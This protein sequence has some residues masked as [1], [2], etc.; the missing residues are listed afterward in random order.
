M[1]YV[2]IQPKTVASPTIE[3]SSDSLEYDGTA[4]EPDV[5]AVKDG[6]NVIPASEYTV[7]Y[8][9]NVNV[10]TAAKVII[11]DV[12]GG[13]Y[14]VSGSRNFTI[15]A[16]AASLINP[17]QPNNLTYT[18]KPQAL[19]TA[20]TAANGRVMYSLE[21]DGTYST[22]IPRG[23]DAD[24]YEVWYKVV[25][26]DGTTETDPYDEPVYVTIDL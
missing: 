23:T 11:T 24:D 17:P 13:N 10:G 7:G 1:V 20:G 15:T 5:L 12:A 16:A 9:N 4:K 26:T 18:G 21:Y 25:S 2:A 22:V 3:L 14:T 6:S 8:S 19:V